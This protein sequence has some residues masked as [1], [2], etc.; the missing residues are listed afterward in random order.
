MWRVSAADGRSSSL[1][2]SVD[3]LDLKRVALLDPQ[4]RFGVGT[5]DVLELSL[6]GFGK[7]V[8]LASPR[9]HRAICDRSIQ[10]NPSA[11]A[12]KGLPQSVS[13]HQISGSH[14]IQS[15]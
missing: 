4:H 7:S 8:M 5:I 2:Q 11:P 15:P 3:R 12:T 13:C 10:S 14:P 1:R 6:P 9:T